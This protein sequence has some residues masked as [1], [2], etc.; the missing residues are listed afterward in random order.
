MRDGSALVS[1]DLVLHSLIDLSARCWCIF[2]A[3]LLRSIFSCCMFGAALTYYAQ[4]LCNAS[5][6]RDTFHKHPFGTSKLAHV[7]QPRVRACRPCMRYDLHLLECM[8]KNVCFDHVYGPPRSQV[9]SSE[10][11]GYNL[12]QKRK[13]ECCASREACERQPHTLT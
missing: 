11:R 5:R 12:H 3:W 6:A 8:C 2:G 9:D 1:T 7:K 13:A 4:S 10:G